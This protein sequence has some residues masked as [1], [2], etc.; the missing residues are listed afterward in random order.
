MRYLSAV[1]TL[2]LAMPAF[3]Q[4]S[5]LK[6]KEGDTIP[7]ITLPAAGAKEATL[8]PARLNGKNVVLFFYP[9]ANTPG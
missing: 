5:T 9:K 7:D 2:G 1:L 4:D 3:A 8:S 6:V